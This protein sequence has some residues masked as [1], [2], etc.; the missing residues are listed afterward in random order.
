MPP[1][2]RRSVRLLGYDYTQP[3]AYFITICLQD[4]WCLFG[5]IEEGTM[6][7]SQVGEIARTCWSNIPDHF[8]HVELNSSVFMPNHM[9]GILV[10]TSNDLTYKHD[11]APV[12]QFGRPVKGSIP[13]IVR[14]Y[15]AT[16]TWRINAAKGTAGEKVWQ[17]NYYE[18]IIRNKDSLWKIQE[19]I[20]NNPLQ[21]DM[22]QLHPANPSRW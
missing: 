22:D 19:Y 20:A 9:H 13:T 6:R 12:E 2:R 17:R 7:L 8:P 11:A 16:T 4:R 15:K 18:H 10:I 5:D 14:S 3:G 1:R 21:W